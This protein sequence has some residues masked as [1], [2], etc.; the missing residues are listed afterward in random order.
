M[1]LSFCVKPSHVHPLQQRLFVCGFDE[2]S[3]YQSRR[4]SHWIT[5]TNLCADSARPAGFQGPHL[6]LSFG[7]VISA[8][9]A[10]RCQ[11]T[12]PSAS[13]IER[14]V[15]FFREAWTTDDS[16]ILVSCDQGA[17]RSPA[18]AYLFI[19]DQLGPGR[20]R[21]AFGLTLEIRPVAVPNE[22]VVRLGDEFLQR[23]GA[24]VAPLKDWYAKIHAELFPK[25]V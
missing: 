6:Q 21:E 2:R 18:L 16:K 10:R 5:V 19:A 14:A 15:G 24:L 12:A 11:T 13:D 25:R 8:A 23:S 20:E 17:S 22:F 9:D 4:I 1:H 3:Q 7:D